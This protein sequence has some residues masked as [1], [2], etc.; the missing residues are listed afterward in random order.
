MQKKFSYP[1]KTD[2]LNQNRYHF[3][4]EADSDELKDITEVLQVEAVRF[5]KGEV[6]LK[7]NKKDNIL[8]VWG[9]VVADL[10]IK[11]VISL[12]NFTQ[13]IDTPFELF[14]DTKATYKD[15]RDINAGIEDEVP[16]IIEN[17]EINLA[18]ICMEQVALQLDDYPR[19]KGEVFDFS[20]YAKVE[21]LEHD[22]PFAVLQ[23]LKK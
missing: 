17:G 16:D 7:F 9:N 18:D 5:F 20:R 21:P 2:E 23:K 19:A 15:I 12:E 1:V 22:N 3:I 8:R 6:F 4:L 14:F 11:S 10:S 13:K